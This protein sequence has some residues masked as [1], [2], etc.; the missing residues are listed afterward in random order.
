MT[1]VT[2]Q[3]AWAILSRHARDEIAPLR[4]QELCR[5]QDRVSALVAVYNSNNDSRTLIA[6]LSRQLLTDTTVNHLLNLATA[7]GLKRLIRQIAWGRNSPEHPVRPLHNKQPKPLQMPMFDKA[8]LHHFH[9]KISAA[10]SHDTVDTLPSAQLRTEMPSIHV[11]LRVPAGKGHE[12][13][14]E[15]GANVLVGIHQ[16]WHRIERFSESVRLGMLK[17]KAGHMI[18]NVVVVGQG[19]A[20]AALQFVY[21]A[22]MKD[23]QAVMAS[24]FGLSQLHDANF[25][26]SGGGRMASLSNLANVLNPNITAAGGTPAVLV[27]RRIKF[28]KTIDPI[29]AASV[30]ADL[31]PAR[32]LV[33][34]IALSGTE[35]TGLATKMLKQWLL[36]G[37]TKTSNSARTVDSVLAKHMILI[38]G[39]ERVATSMHKPESVHVIPE[40]ARCEGFSTC[41]AATLL[42]RACSQ[43]R[44]R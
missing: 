36:R 29:A 8:K 22:L 2:P 44:S 39:N 21:A 17:G 19:V 13:F 25:S 28:L 23:E 7:V 5:D 41:T 32:T 26:N 35:E 20:V 18:L 4:L 34:S 16:E 30:V 24:R 14:D 37:M 15:S 43:H 38:T 11:A 10:A 6:D 9:Q 42:V 12:M 40:H 1:T 3:Q 27:G 31:D 33:I